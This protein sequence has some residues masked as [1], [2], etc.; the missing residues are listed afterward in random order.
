LYNLKIFVG[1]QVKT[2]QKKLQE[3]GEKMDSVKMKVGVIIL[4]LAGILCFFPPTQAAA[5]TQGE[6]AVLLAAE[7]GLGEGLTAEQ[8]ATALEEVGIV[9]GDGWQLDSD[10]TCELVDEVQILTIK[11]AQE[12]L[13]AF[14][15]EEITPLMAMVSEKSGACAPTVAA[16]VPPAG[17]AP[18]PAPIAP[19]IRG[20]GG[21]GGTQSPSI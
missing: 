15:P 21:G 18:A 8:A 7:L 2:I 14:A 10:V 9:P 17:A 4:V 11:A 20:G 1:I 6:Y 16:I 19:E 5:V 3:G 12:G 13:I